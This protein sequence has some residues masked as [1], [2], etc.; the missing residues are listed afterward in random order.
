MIQKTFILIFLSFSIAFSQSD[1]LLI[2]SE[3]MFSP[4]SGNNEFIEIYNLSNSESVDLGQYK[5]KYYTSNPDII[6]DAGEGT[7]LPPKSFAIILEN[8]Y[9]IGSGIYDGLIPAEAL[10]LKISDN[11]FGTN[12]MANT[13]SRPIWLINNVEDTLESYFYSANNTQAHSDEKIILVKNS[14]QSNWA[15][16]LVADGTP[17]F[18][19]SVTPVQF[20][21]QIS[22][23]PGRR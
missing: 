5:I 10:V 20:D 11:A 3:I 1:T 19:N 17:G 8:D 23:R 16:S 13:T 15:N 4:T 18:Q 21:L 9:V 22:N 6:V 12:G 14:S 7:V 2:F